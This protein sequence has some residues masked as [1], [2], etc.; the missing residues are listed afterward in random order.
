MP[1]GTLL[2][3]NGLPENVSLKTGQKLVVPGFGG[4]AGN[5]QA[6][7]KVASA[8]PE[9]TLKL[10]DAQRSQ[11]ASATRQSGQRNGLPAAAAES[12]AGHTGNL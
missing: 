5:T 11:G 6:Q 9:H 8:E 7:P 2:A 12:G 10:P 3:A 1:V 4:K